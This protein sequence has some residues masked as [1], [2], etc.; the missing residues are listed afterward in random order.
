M[1]VDYDMYVEERMSNAESLY[2]RK[3]M[4]QAFLIGFGT[5]FVLLGVFEYKGWVVEHPIVSYNYF[6][7]YSTVISN[8]VFIHSRLKSSTLEMERYTTLLSSWIKICFQI[9]PT[10]IVKSRQMKNIHS[11]RKITN[12]L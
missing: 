10:S 8:L 1:H 6:L 5:L 3:Q 4:L 12:V 11:A 9:F 7:S 2:S